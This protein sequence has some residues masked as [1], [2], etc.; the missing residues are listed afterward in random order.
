MAEDS[1]SSSSVLHPPAD[2]RVDHFPNVGILQR[3]L[4]S[5]ASLFIQTNTDYAAA[6]I[7][8]HTPPHR[9]HGILGPSRHRHAEI[10]N[11]LTLESLTIPGYNTVTKIIF[12][13]RIETLPRGDTTTI[14]QTAHD[15]FRY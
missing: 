14:K 15:N 12:L 9:P 3:H 4:S 10:D 6:P 5:S 13:R 7:C 1:S 8:L 11:T 2:G